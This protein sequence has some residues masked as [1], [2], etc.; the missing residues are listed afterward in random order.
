MKKLEEKA[1]LLKN[2]LALDYS[3]IAVAF[4]DKPIKNEDK[5][6]RV[7]RGLL[8]AGKGQI[9]QIDRKNCQCFGASWHLGFRKITDKKVLDMIR[10]FVVE[11]EKLFCDYAA[12]DNIIEDMGE[13]LDNS[14]R[15]LV[16]CPLE[17]AAFKPEIVLLRADVIA[18]GLDHKCRP[19]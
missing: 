7:C 11:G 9:L 17:K 16:L 4:L 14:S 2:L 12:L 8:D 15:Y 5:K 13:I 6:I 1:N 10:K 19:V 18:V 3:P